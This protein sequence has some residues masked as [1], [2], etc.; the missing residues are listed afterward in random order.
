MNTDKKFRESPIVPEIYV[1]VDVD[2]YC[3]F[4]IILTT[5]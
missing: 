3:L 5:V 4:V 2:G 1:R